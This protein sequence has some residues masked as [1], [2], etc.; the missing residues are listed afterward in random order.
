MSTEMLITQQSEEVSM[1]MFDVLSIDILKNFIY[2]FKF[3]WIWIIELSIFAVVLFS[4]ADLKILLL[5]VF[6]LYDLFYR[7]GKK[8]FNKP[9]I[10]FDYTSNTKK[11]Y[12]I[13]STPF[14]KFFIRGG[15]ELF[16][17]SLSSINWLPVL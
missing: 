8:E 13:T 11:S 1:F 7:L 2:K 12:K 5:I 9:R 14:L 10:R 6:A 3:R 15:V 17:S 16:S 4:E